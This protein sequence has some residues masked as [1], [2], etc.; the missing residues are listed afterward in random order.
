M[1]SYGIPYY[2]IVIVE[3]NRALSFKRMEDPR[4]TTRYT[5]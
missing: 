5:E 3:N 1:T 4:L 2:G